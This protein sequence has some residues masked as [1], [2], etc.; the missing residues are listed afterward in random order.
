[1]VNSTINKPMQWNIAVLASLRN[2][3]SDWIIEV[4]YL[5]DSSLI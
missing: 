5:R 2:N 3:K 1:M 4:V